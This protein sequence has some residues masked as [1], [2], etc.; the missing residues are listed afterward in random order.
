[1]VSNILQTDGTLQTAR[2]ERMRLLLADAPT[3]APTSAPSSRPASRPSQDLG[4]MANKTIR[5]VHFLDSAVLNSTL[6]DAKG[7]L[8]RSMQLESQQ[9]EYDLPSR[10]LLVPMAGKM[11]MEDHRPPAAATSQPT[12]DMR[13]VTWFVWD[14]QLDYNPQ[15]RIALLEGNVRVAHADEK[16][17]SQQTHLTADS[18]TAD[19]EPVPTN[20]ATRPGAPEVRLRRARGNGNVVFKRSTDHLE[21]ESA[22]LDPTARLLALRGTE[23][24]PVKRLATEGPFKGMVSG[25]FREA[26]VNI[27]TWQIKEAGQISGRVLSPPRPATQP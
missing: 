24:N 17:P 9:I 6:T 20:A 1:V 8:L 21:A 2:S 14:K 18:F 12:G 13:G 5:Q 7:K 19:L 26:L 3:T 10:R 4:P 16:D 23:R 11:G 25:T 27:D 15:Q 22:E